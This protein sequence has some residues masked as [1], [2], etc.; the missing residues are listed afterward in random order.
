ME[1]SRLLG[2]R[3]PINRSNR[4][5]RRTAC[6]PLSPSTSGAEVNACRT[7]ELMIVASSLLLMLSPQLWT[8]KRIANLA[9]LNLFLRI[10]RHIESIQRILLPCAHESCAL[11]Q[12]Q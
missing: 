3:L 9:G 5:V 11:I 8:I 7:S 10:G 1:G 6:T 12:T 4:L 2:G